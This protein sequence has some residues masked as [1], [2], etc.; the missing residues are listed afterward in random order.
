[1]CIFFFFFLNDTAPP[2]IYPLPLHDALPILRLDA[3][4]SEI[5]LGMGR[6]YVEIGQP[7]QAVEY[8]RRA[9]RLLPDRVEPHHWLGRTLIQI[10]RV[11]EGKRELAKVEQM[12]A[13]KREQAVENLSREISPA[14]VGSPDAGDQRH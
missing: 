11:E 4:Y 2:E 14:S 1:M 7:R 12:N 9:A 10:G 5:Y 8:F 6:A 3:S 13:K